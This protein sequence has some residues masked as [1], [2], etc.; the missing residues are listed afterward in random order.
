MKP[1]RRAHLAD[2]HDPNCKEKGKKKKRKSDDNLLARPPP[3][4]QSLQPLKTFF[5]IQAIE[6]W[7]TWGQIAPGVDNG[8]SEIKLTKLEFPGPRRSRRS[9]SPTRGSRGSCR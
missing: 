2:I 4:P 7:G 9:T 3:Q 6:K 8:Q 5:E 1:L